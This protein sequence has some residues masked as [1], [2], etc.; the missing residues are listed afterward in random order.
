[1][2]DLQSEFDSR[3]IALQ[4]VGIKGLRYPIKLRDRQNEVQSTVASVS[5]FVDLSSSVRG[6]H[7]SR[8]VEILWSNRTEMTLQSIQK[9]LRQMLD[10]L[11]S[12]SAYI[13]L[14]FPYFIEKVA[15]VS[16]LKGLMD[17]DCVFSASLDRN[18]SKIN[19]ILEVHVPVKSLCP[20]S[21]EISSKG[22][23][24]QRSVVA[25]AVRCREFV[26]I[27]ELV[28][29]AENAASSALYSVLKREDEKFVTEQAYEN[30]VFVEDIVRVIA[31]KLGSDKR[32]IWFRAES[33][34]FESIHNHNA[35]AS[36]ERSS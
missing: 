28:E 26:W 7:M 32:I 12:E 17:Y 4:K 30:P 16:K 13:E 19:S 23:H 10:N 14:K 5:M 35:F 29:I 25:I 34:N 21:K 31:Q 3:G 8:L 2:K 33:E 22:A 1:M 18:N 9:V 6:I 20:C 27:E 24:N 36:I 11:N 15:P